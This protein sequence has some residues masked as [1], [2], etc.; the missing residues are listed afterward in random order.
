MTIPR[1]GVLSWSKQYGNRRA[2]WL[3]A[4]TILLPISGPCPILG[5]LS[6]P[7]P[8]GTE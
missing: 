7:E 8:G 6:D 3:F 5:F 4:A 2:L 1:E